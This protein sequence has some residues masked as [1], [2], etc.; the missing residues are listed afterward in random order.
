MDINPTVV[1][2]ES[3]PGKSVTVCPATYRMGLRRTLLM[4]QERKAIKDKGEVE[5]DLASSVGASMIYPTLIAAV[6]DHAGFDAWPPTSDQVM[7]MPEGFVMV[8]EKA[9]YECNPQWR[10]VL[11]EEKKA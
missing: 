10:A 1:T 4:E 2:H 7:D 5:V 11:P 8:W 6:V 3:L 9:A